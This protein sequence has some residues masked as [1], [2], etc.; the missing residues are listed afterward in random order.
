[1][2]TRTHPGIFPIRIHSPSR[3][4]SILKHG[5]YVF[6]LALRGVMDSDIGG[7]RVMKPLGSVGGQAPFHIIAR[8]AVPIRV[9]R[10]RAQSVPGDLGRVGRG[11]LREVRSAAREC[12]HGELG[13]LPLGKSTALRRQAVWI[14]STA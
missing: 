8:I 5:I 13:S 2:S 4:S 14:I 10:S 6:T 1:M 7:P 12:T 11:T 3:S 9:P